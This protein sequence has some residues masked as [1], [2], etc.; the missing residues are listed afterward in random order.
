MSLGNCEFYVDD[1]R[2]DLSI[3]QAWGRAALPAEEAEDELCQALQSAPGGWPS[4]GKS[5]SSRILSCSSATS[6]SRLQFCTNFDIE[7]IKVLTL[8]GCEDCARLHP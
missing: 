5:S 6:E 4:V 2:V 1:Q 8:F 3:P 7:C